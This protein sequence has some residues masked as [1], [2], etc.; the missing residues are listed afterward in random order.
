MIQSNHPYDTVQIT[1]KRELAI[2]FA[3]ITE[4]AALA[5]YQWLG[6][7][8][9]N[10]AD[11]A[12]VNVIRIELNKIKMDGEIVIS[13]GEIDKAAMIFIGEKVG[14]GGGECI[15]I[16][17]D[18]I[19]GTRMTAMG[20]NNA[21]AVLAAGVKNSFLKAPDMYMEKLVVGPSVKNVIDL[22]RTLKENIYNIAQSLCKPFTSLTIMTL[23]KPRHESAITMM[24]TMGIKVFAIPDGDIAASILTCMSGSVID[25]M[26]CI[27]GAPEG[28]ISAAAIRGLGGDMQGRLMTRDDVKGA[29]EE[30]KTAGAMER[31]R[32][33]AIGIEIGK[34]LHL[35]DIVGSDNVIFSATGITKGDLLEGIS[36]KNNIAETDTLVIRSQSHTVRRIKSIYDLD[37]ADDDIKDFIL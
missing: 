13:E 3:H 31:I 7:G 33:Q 21:I 36:R 24:R 9:K 32:C 6:R 17:V 35:E 2:E 5:S 28:V 23:A 11:D 27:G 18:P 30:N 8:N 19:E 10:A 16:A 1:M 15:D 29:S 20:Q 37:R 34:L 22:N 25:M 26:Y 4:V 14:K 12:A